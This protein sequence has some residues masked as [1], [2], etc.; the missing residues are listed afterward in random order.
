MNRDTDDRAPAQPDETVQGAALPL[1]TEADGKKSQRQSGRRRNTLFI[2]IAALVVL[3][4]V[5]AWALFP[6][7]PNEGQ[8]QAVASATPPAPAPTTTAQPT[9]TLRLTDY[10][11]PTHGFAVKLLSPPT[12]SKVAIPLTSDTTVTADVFSAEYH[13]QSVIAVPLPCMNPA[14]TTEILQGFMDSTVSNSGKS[15]SAPPVVE[16]R[17]PTTLQ[18]FPAIRGKFTYTDTDGRRLTAQILTVMHGST[19]IQALAISGSSP[20]AFLDAGQKAFMDSLRF[21]DRPAPSAPMCDPSQLPGA[22]G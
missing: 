8:H 16:T 19:I 6:Q 1:S 14:H 3:C 11:D 20:D 18:S 21:L 17:D 13:G 2:G 22:A 4:G 12:H 7:V 5:G 10:T 15:T 9:P